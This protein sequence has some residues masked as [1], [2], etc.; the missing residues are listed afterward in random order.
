MKK[1]ELLPTKFT[2]LTDA[3]LFFDLPEPKHPL[4]SL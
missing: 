2:S 3:H 4:V 1:D